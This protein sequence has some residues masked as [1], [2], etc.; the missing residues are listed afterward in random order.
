VAGAQTVRRSAAHHG[1]GSTAVAFRTW[2]WG[3]NK[4][5][6]A[7]RLS[8]CIWPCLLRLYHMLPRVHWAACRER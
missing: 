3:R 5:V 7:V 6:P 4:P 1:S 2:P 8:L